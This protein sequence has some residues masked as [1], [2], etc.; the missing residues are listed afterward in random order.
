MRPLYMV[1]TKFILVELFCSGKLAME[2]A[3]AVLSGG[4]SVVSL[5]AQF[6]YFSRQRS[7]LFSFFYLARVF[8]DY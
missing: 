2:A 8:W 4:I 5:T 7:F 6:V 3:C 1:N